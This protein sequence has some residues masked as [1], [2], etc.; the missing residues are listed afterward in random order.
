MA[1][2][3]LL[4]VLSLLLSSAFADSDKEK[5][6]SLV[7]SLPKVTKA[8]IKR[9]NTE[10][11]IDLSSS[12]AKSEIE[13]FDVIILEEGVYTTL[14]DF[15]AKYV[16]VRGQ[17]PGKTIISTTNRFISPILVNST[18]LWDATVVDT[19]FKIGDLNGLWAVNVEFVGSILVKPAAMDKSPAFAIRSVF[20]DI[21]NSDLSMADENLYSHF[22][23]KKGEQYLMPLPG[24]YKAL[25]DSASRLLAYEDQFDRSKNMNLKN[26]IGYKG[27]FA[28]GLN[29]LYQK[30][31]LKPK[32]DHSKYV[33]LTKN[34]R[35]TKA[36]GHL[37]VAM[38]YWAEADRLSGHSQFDE[39]LKEITPLSQSLSQD[40]GCTV[41]GQGLASSIKNEIEQKLYTKLPITGLPG[42]CKIQTLHVN[43][44]AGMK[45]EAMI[46]AAREQNQMNQEMA[47]KANEQ[48]FQK[49]VIAH[50][51][52]TA[53][54]TDEEMLL[55]AEAPVASTD[56]TAVA[57]V[58]MPGMKKS[59]SS[60]VK[61]N[62]NKK[63][64]D[65][66]IVD[67]LITTIMKKLSSNIKAAK[68]KIASSNVAVKIDGLI[69]Q[70]LY[71][72]EIR[73]KE[74]E[75]IHEQQFGRKVSSVGATSSVFAY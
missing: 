45:K 19:Q 25:K 8:K 64:L 6:Y 9:G 27:L 39:V 52:K 50:Y 58:E 13:D 53:T 57:D 56:Y 34:A 28:R 75:D 62:N 44:P 68:A 74:Y 70:A 60:D 1:L 14:G 51:S 33:Q 54:D 24:D 30:D 36:A 38:L 72:E 49:S 7:T 69:A 26:R 15:T 67:P 48:A 5:I 4:L 29:Y 59:F 12:N 42:K 23:T 3:R 17:G 71:G 41:E 16:R 63:S 65:Q 61:A 21:T 31:V 47:F 32:Y 18:E 40:C 43:V 20:S 37:Y 73:Q 22:L 2:C 66:N 11:P 35:S 46:A 10:I 55:G